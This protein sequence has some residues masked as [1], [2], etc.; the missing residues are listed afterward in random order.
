VHGD[1]A[2]AAGEEEEKSSAGGG[3]AAQC[4]AALRAPGGYLPTCN[5][6]LAALLRDDKWLWKQP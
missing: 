6:R 2:A 1:R 4:E 3:P 5:A